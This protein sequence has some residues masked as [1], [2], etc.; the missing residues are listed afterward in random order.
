MEFK[1]L[2]QQNHPLL[3]GNVWDVTSTKIAEKLNFKAVGTSSAAIATTLGYTDGEEMKFSE[4]EY[5]VKRI[6]ANTKL[7]VSVDLES[8]Y[9][10]DP[11]KIV[12]HI[13][14]LCDL[15][16]AGINLEDSVVC[17]ERILLHA[18][19]FA[20]TLSFI[21]NELQKS[22]LNI[23]LNIRV[24]TF[25]LGQSKPIEESQKRIHLYEQAG[26]DGI[27]LPGI[28]K[29]G[30]IKKMVKKTSL[31]INVM[32][33]PNLPDFNRLNELGVKRISMGN[34]LFKHL[35]KNHKELTAQL[36]SQKSF[37]PIFYHANN[38]KRKN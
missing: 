37:K 26:A 3:I 29:E 5:I 38:R 30:D 22:Q 17:K 2:H 12:N 25:L 1:A 19:T 33:M 6:L 36:L 13:K 35:Y 18:E 11:V 21:K 14:Q 23:F 16:V 10:R 32:C 24:D 7:P 34:F 9:S 15:G 31:P 27:F 28:E 8:G 20:E 4:L